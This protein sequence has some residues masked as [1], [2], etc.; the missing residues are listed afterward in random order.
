[1]LFGRVVVDDQ[2]LQ[3]F[4]VNPARSAA[5]RAGP[6]QHLLVG[7]Q[8]LAEAGE[9]RRIEDD[10][11]LRAVVL[12]VVRGLTGHEPRELRFV[13]TDDGLRAYLTLGLDAAAPLAEAHARASEI[14]EQIRRERPETADVIVHT[15]P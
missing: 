13:R 15:E 4:G 12:R 1:M 3:A 8:P 11:A 2:S 14:E 5:L 7:L 6:N 10:S 9:G